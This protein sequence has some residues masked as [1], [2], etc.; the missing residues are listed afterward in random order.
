MQQ[1]PRRASQPE[2]AKDLKELDTRLTYKSPVYHFTSIL[3]FGELRSSQASFAPVSAIRVSPHMLKAV[4]LLT[5]QARTSPS[6]RPKNAPKDLACNP[7]WS[8]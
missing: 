1:E 2:E 8:L 6:S 7:C 4:S 3:S 5:A